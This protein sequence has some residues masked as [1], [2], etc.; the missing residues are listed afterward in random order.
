MSSIEKQLDAIGMQLQSHSRNYF[1]VDWQYIEQGFGIS[2]PEDYR[3]F[4]SRFGPW[5]FAEFTI[6]N[7]IEMQLHDGQEKS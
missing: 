1:E 3:L 5:R 7:P 6:F 4:I 2:L